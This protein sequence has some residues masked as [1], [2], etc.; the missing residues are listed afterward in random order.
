[1]TYVNRTVDRT[2]GIYGQLIYNTFTLISQSEQ[3]K[4][5]FRKYVGL[6]MHIK[7]NFCAS[8]IMLLIEMCLFEVVKEAVKSFWGSPWG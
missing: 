4:V 1:M 3:F 8:D 7:R 5:I 6:T 2:P